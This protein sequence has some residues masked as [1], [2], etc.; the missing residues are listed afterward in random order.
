MELCGIIA[1]QQSAPYPSLLKAS[2]VTSITDCYLDQLL[3][4]FSADDTIL[5]LKVEEQ[6]NGESNMVPYPSPSRPLDIASTTGCSQD[7]PPTESIVINS[8]S[9]SMEIEKQA[10]GEPNELCRL[11]GIENTLEHFK[12]AHSSSRYSCERPGSFEDFQSP[13][14]RSSHPALIHELFWYLCPSPGCLKRFMSLDATQVHVAGSHDPVDL[15]EREKTI[16]RTLEQV[17]E[18]SLAF[19]D[20]KCERCHPPLRWKYYRAV[21]QATSRAHLMSRGLL[22]QTFADPGHQRAMSPAPEMSGSRTAS[23]LAYTDG[24]CKDCQLTPGAPR[25]SHK[26][27]KYMGLWIVFL[28]IPEGPKLDKFIDDTLLGCEVSQVCHWAPCLVLAHLEHV[29]RYFNNNRTICKNRRMRRTSQFTQTL[30]L[31]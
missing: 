17:R 10:D 9:S 6:A 24:G 22:P 2:N 29:P 15:P 5:R 12:Q 1:R 8:I 14:E 20:A 13:E 16:S 18:S 3:P 31:W 30:S 23:R 26:I 7:Q 28:S 25:L 19:I 11:C 4:I 21:Q 27:Y